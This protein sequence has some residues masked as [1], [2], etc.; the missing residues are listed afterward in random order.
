MQAALFGEILPIFANFVQNIATEKNAID[1]LSSGLKFCST[2]PK[3]ISKC[4]QQKYYESCITMY[5][6]ILNLIQRLPF[7]KFVF[8]F[9]FFEHHIEVDKN[10]RNDISIIFGFVCHVRKV[11]NSNLYAEE[12]IPNKSSRFK[13]SVLKSYLLS[14]IWP[15]K[16]FFAHLFRQHSR[17]VTPIFGYFV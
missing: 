6:N 13:F 7:Y 16:L 1:L 4:P 8:T 11:N 17:R 9:R 5:Y 14:L 15:L 10:P 12:N 2:L 3:M